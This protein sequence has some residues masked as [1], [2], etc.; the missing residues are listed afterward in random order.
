MEQKSGKDIEKGWSDSIENWVSKVWQ[1][2][3]TWE[4]K[5]EG[6]SAHH[7]KDIL[8]WKESGRHRGLENICW[9]L[10]IPISQ[11]PPWFEWR[12]VFITNINM[13]PVKCGNTC[14]TAWHCPWQHI[15]DLEGSAAPLASY[16]TLKHP[17]LRLHVAGKQLHCGSAQP[18]GHGWTLQ[19]HY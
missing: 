16:R 7:R 1:N 6:K 5:A 12:P 14:D 19:G 17:S 11:P 13:S 15:L 3:E 9:S 8:K 4:Y 10:P 18:D 2:S